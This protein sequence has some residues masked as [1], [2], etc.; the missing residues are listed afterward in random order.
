MVEFLVIVAFLL[1]CATALFVHLA[2]NEPRRYSSE[3]LR[4]DLLIADHHITDEYRQARRAMNAAA[5][6]SWRNLAG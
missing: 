5:G 3:H 1:F 4:D 6:Q 2:G